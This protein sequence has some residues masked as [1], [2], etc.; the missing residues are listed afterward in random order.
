LTPECLQTDF[1][2]NLEDFPE[3]NFTCI[4]EAHSLSELSHNFRTS[5]LA[6]GDIVLNIIKYK[7]NKPTILGLTA[8]ANPET[9]QSIK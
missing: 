7:N 5:F 8:T 6:L 3:V 1:I 9:V 4:D 2:Y